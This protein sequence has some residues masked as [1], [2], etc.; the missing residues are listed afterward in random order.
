MFSGGRNVISRAEETESGSE[1]Y[2]EGEE[3]LILRLNWRCDRFIERESRDGS[4]LALDRGRGF[5]ESL[6]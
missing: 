5:K 1:I 4:G 3:D 2:E 6:S